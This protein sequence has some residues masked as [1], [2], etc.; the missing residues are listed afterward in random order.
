KGTGYVTDVGMTGPVRSV[1]GVRPEQSIN[2]FLGNPPVR[3]EPSSDSGK[4]EFAVFEIDTDTGL[5]VSA[6]TFRV[7]V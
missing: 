1:I 4:I 2:K 7:L 3:Y 5:C 6:E